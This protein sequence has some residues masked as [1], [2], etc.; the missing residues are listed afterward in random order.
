MLEQVNRCN[1]KTT[2]C[3]L[4]PGGYPREFY[5]TLQNQGFEITVRP[6]MP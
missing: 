5:R 3:T 6:S 1:V 4:Y 2:W